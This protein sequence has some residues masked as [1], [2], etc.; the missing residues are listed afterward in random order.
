MKEKDEYANW[1]KQRLREKDFV[2]KESR[3]EKKLNFEKHSV[4]RKEQKSIYDPRAGIIDLIYLNPISPNS[5]YYLRD[6]VVAISLRNEATGRERRLGLEELLLDEIMS[7]DTRC[8]SLGIPAGVYS[9][10]MI[11][12]NGQGSRSKRFKAESNITLIAYF[13]ED[14]TYWTKRLGKY[15]RDNPIHER[16]E[17]DQSKRKMDETIPKNL[18]NI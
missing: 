3:S 8:W 16:F 12:G 7:Y 14:Y 11:R 18:I 2:K 13:F 6:S 1:I 4:K 10:A 5:E 9:I 15:F 17:V